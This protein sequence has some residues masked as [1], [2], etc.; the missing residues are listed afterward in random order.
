V[1]YVTMLTILLLYAGKKI[2]HLFIIRCLSKY[3]FGIYLIHWLIQQI[4]APYFADLNGS[5]LQVFGLFFTSLIFSIFIIRLISLI[6][7]SEFMIVNIKN[8]P[9]IS[10]LLIYIL[11]LILKVK[12]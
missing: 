8:I 7:F 10:N 11:V 4:I 6:P 3:A 2:P 9:S 5:F 1:P 12:S